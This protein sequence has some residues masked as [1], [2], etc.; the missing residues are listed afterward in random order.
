MRNPNGYGSVARLS[1]NRRRP[2]IVKKV[3]GWKDNGQ[4]VYS[5]IGYTETRE[6]GNILLAEYNRDPWN[7]DQAK[8]TLQQLF[9]LW[10]EKKAS[11]LGKSNREALRAAFRH[12]SKLVGQPYKSIKAFQMQDTIDGCGRGPS[13]QAAI[14]NLWSHLDRFALEMD[15]ITRRYSDLLTAAP[16]P[17][18]TRTRLTDEE[19]AR[20]WDHQAEPWVDVAL[21][22]VY[23]GWRISELLALTPA[24]VDPVA[25]TMT[26]GTKTKAGKGRVVPI[27]S[28]I[29]PLVDAR[30]AEG[31]PR[32]ICY[33]GRPIPKTTF[34]LLW[35]GMM[36]QVGMS[37][38]PHECRHTFE[39]LLDSAGA[40]RRCIDLMMGHVSKDTGNRVYNHKT[41]DELKA[42]VELIKV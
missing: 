21:I 14:K 36:E 11:K 10:K 42:T 20:L 1:G 25:G 40:N 16:A 29:R 24:D 7:V 18:T 31:G 4:P 41:I 19:I 9:D 30:L 8:I 38:V 3:T 6:A 12:C 32:L 39:S 15:I 34:R 35:G 33:G 22:L 27:H 2:F 23:S 37:H 13:T 26:G 5:I 17:E 28:K